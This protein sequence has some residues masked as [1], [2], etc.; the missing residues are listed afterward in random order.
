[1]H[2]YQRDGVLS[3]DR[4]APLAAVTKQPLEPNDCE[5]VTADSKVD[6]EGGMDGRVDPIWSIHPSI[7]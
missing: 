7:V 3:P 5:E 2:P 6:S 4:I 1:M